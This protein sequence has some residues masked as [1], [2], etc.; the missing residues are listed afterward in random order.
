MLPHIAHPGFISIDEEALKYNSVDGSSFARKFKIDLDLWVIPD[1]YNT[2]KTTE[3]TP[4]YADFDDLSFGKAIKTPNG[5]D[6][7]ITIL[8]STRSGERLDTLAA[9]LTASTLAITPQ[10]TESS[11]PLD[12][13]PISLRPLPRNILSMIEVPLGFIGG[14]PRGWSGG[15][16]KATS[17]PS[18]ELDNGCVLAFIDRDFWVRTWS[19][20]DIDG[21]YSKQHFFLPRD[22]IRLDTLRLASVTPDGRLLCPRAGEVAVVHNGFTAEWVA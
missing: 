16:S 1:P 8:K 9:F 17:Q 15:T 10:D 6:T 14:T 22:W 13:T 3:K 18:P 20:D 11:A 4:Q 7:L 19:L 5:S 12:P 2:E 21:M